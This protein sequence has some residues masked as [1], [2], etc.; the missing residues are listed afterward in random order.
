MSASSLPDKNLYSID[1]IGPLQQPGL[2]VDVLV[3]EFIFR[4]SSL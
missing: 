4:R 1:R 2:S 3:I